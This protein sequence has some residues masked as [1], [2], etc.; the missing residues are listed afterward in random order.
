MGR[1]VKGFRLRADPDAVRDSVSLR[2]R[3]TCCVVLGWIF[4]VR[5]RKLTTGRVNDRGLRPPGFV[6]PQTHRSD[7]RVRGLGENGLNRGN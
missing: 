6:C 2:P 1:A 4:R 5:A 3:D 7:P